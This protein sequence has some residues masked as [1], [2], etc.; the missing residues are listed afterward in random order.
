[1]RGGVTPATRYNRPMRIVAF[2]LVAAL[3]IAGWWWRVADRSSAPPEF[4]VKS[5]ERAVAPAPSRETSLPPPSS[6][7]PTGTTVAVPAER[8]VMPPLRLVVLARVAFPGEA[9]AITVLIDGQSH[10]LREGHRFGNGFRVDTIGTDRVS[11]THLPSGQ[12]VEK[13]I[14][15]LASGTS[16]ATTSTT[17]ES[18][19]TGPFP[20]VTSRVPVPPTFAPAATV[21]TPASAPVTV[22]PASAPQAPPGATRMDNPLVGAVLPNASGQA[23]AG[24]SGP[25]PIPLPPGQ[26]APAGPQLRQVEPG[27]PVPVPR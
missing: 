25:K 8:A 14:D 9:P 19:Q 20:A 26:P 15:E 18:V 1:V 7:P 23:P 2:L 11:F 16:T 5:V 10:T 17:P 24:V 6:P 12:S 27:T 22:A 21:P 3:A 13:R 4:P